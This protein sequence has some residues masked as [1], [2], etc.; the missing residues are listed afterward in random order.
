MNEKT[1]EKR[2]TDPKTGKF[3]K[4]NP[5]KPKGAKHFTTQLREFIKSKGKDE[6]LREVIL[7]KMMEGE[8]SFIKEYWEQIDG[9][10]EQKNEV[11]LDEETIK[12][13]NVVK[14]SYNKSSTKAN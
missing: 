7:S 5:G 6:E 10:P 3:K 9:K 2:Y 13:I 1:S 4:G 11:G 8:F 12:T 14:N